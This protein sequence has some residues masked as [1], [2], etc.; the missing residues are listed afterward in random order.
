MVPPNRSCLLSQNSCSAN[1]GLDQD[2]ANSVA[3]ADRQAFAAVANA[4]CSCDQRSQS[5]CIRTATSVNATGSVPSTNTTTRNPNS[6]PIGQPRPVDQ[7]GAP[8]D[9][10]LSPIE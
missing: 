5:Q 2:Q 1:R 6:V 9:V 8:K 3:G 7:A 10:F 4:G